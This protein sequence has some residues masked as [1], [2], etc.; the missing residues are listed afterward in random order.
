M[1]EI[2]Y[3]AVVIVGIGFVLMG[4]SGSIKSSIFSTTLTALGIMAIAFGG[5]KIWKRKKD[6]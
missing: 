6:R 2:N 5:Y 1:K 3:G 4:T